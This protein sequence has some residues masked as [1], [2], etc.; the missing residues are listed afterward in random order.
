MTNIADTV[1]DT[2]I[3]VSGDENGTQS[4]GQ[5]SIYLVNWYLEE[6]VYPFEED[7]SDFN[8]MDKD[9]VGGA[10]GN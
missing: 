9:Y 7:D 10:L 4:Y 6:L 5:V 1:N 8:P 3:K 2:Y